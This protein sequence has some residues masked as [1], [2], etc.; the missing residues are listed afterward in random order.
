MTQLIIAALI[1]GP[2]GLTQSEIIAALIVGVPILLSVLK[3]V[4]LD[5]TRLPR[6]A[7][8]LPPFLLAGLPELVLRL[9]AGTDLLSSGVDAVLA[10]LAAIGVYHTAKRV[11]P[12]KT[13]VV[14]L[15]LI[16]LST[17]TGCALV[18]PEGP[19]GPPK[20]AVCVKVTWFSAVE[21]YLCARTQAELLQ[22]TRELRATGRVRSI[23]PLH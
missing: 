18:H 15:L 10:G 20:D 4:S 11:G 3:A 21:T 2:S 7:Q 23:S 8:W 13:A 5:V 9:Q 22:A 14:G 1:I 17:P 19:V 12:A 16:V 6:W